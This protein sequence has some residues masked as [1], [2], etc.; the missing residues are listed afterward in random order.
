M[1][2]RV[3]ESLN[4]PVMRLLKPLTK[5]NVEVLSVK[6]RYLCTGTCVLIISAN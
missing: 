5:R 3:I 1:P 4:K 2:T 6:K